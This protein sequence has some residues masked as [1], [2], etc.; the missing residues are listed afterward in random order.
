MAPAHNQLLSPLTDYLGICG[1]N[2]AGTVNVPYEHRDFLPKLEALRYR[3]QDKGERRQEV[4]DKTAGEMAAILGAVPG[5]A[6]AL[7]DAAGDVLTHL[8][9]VLSASE[10][11]LLPFELSKVPK[12]CAGGEGNNL[13]LQT[14]A[15]ICL[16]RRVRSVAKGR[17]QWPLKP[18]ILFVAAAPRGMRIPMEQHTQALLKAILPWMKPF[19]PGDAEDLNKKAGEILTILPKATME[20]V[21]AACAKTFY[22]HVH[23]LAHGI[24]APDLPGAPF[25]LALH[26]RLGEDK[27][28]VVSGARFATAPAP[29]APGN[30][31]HGVAGGGDGGQLR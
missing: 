8:E 13:S 18:R 5:F 12:G 24:E 2:G 7:A 25:G 31:R 17:L 29:L 14:L 28:D 4:L 30:T 21:E 23:V 27:I 20:D 19:T 15:P 6:G 10:L 26:S 11:A 16:T 22:T 3:A 9:L 1:N